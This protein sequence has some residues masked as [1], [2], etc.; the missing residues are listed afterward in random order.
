MSVWIHPHN[1]IPAHIGIQV[2]P[3]VKPYW[4]FR[5]KPPD[6]GI[7]VS[8]PHVIQVVAFVNNPYLTGILERLGNGFCLRHDPAVRVVG[9]G[10][11]G[12]LSAV[13]DCDGV[14]GAVEVVDVEG[15]G[16]GQ[17]ITG[18]IV[19]VFGDH[20]VAGGLDPV[21]DAVIH[22]AAGALANQLVGVVKAEVG[23][24]LGFKLAFAVVGVWGGR[25]VELAVVQSV[26][27][28]VVAVGLG[29]VD[30]LFR[31]LR[32][33]RQSLSSVA[34]GIEGVLPGYVLCDPILCLLRS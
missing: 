33:G 15:V 5:Y 21:A 10:V 12:L 2:Q 14:T 13:C 1:R 32:L 4:I 22:I 24:A 16:L 3:A 34:V 8:G 31:Q 26:F 25:T 27:L 20:A 9:V 17:Q 30:E 19:D 11:D 23:S 28:G 6:V 29:L 18:G 7:V